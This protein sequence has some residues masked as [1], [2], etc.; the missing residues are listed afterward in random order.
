MGS[1]RL[2]L[3]N[4][5]I[6]ASLAS[7]AS[8]A[9]EKTERDSPLARASRLAASKNTRDRVQALRWL[10]ALAKP[11]KGPQGDEATYRYAELCLRFHREGERGAL[12][13]AKRAFTE[14][15]SKSR[16]RWGLLG[17][18]GTLRIMAAEGKRQE[19]LKQLDRFLSTQGKDDAFVDAAFYMGCLLAEDKDSLQSL[20]KARKAC[21]YALGLLKSR[22][23]YYAGL[24]T[25][26]RIRR[27][28]RQLKWD[29]DKLQLGRDFLMYRTAES[30]R[31][32]RRDLKKA[33]SLYL[34]VVKEHP[35][36][37][38]AE[39]SALYA[40]LC[41]VALNRPA[42]AHGELVAFYRA[43][44]RGLYRGEALLE[45]ARLEI[46]YYIR[47]DAARAY[48]GQLK[49][50]MRSAREDRTVSITGVKQAAKKLVAPP[51]TEK[52][53]D[54]WGNVRRQ[55][56][57]PGQLV[58]RLTCSWYLDEI[59]E[60][61]AAF[62]GF[63]FFAQGRRKEALECYR[64]LLRSDS[65]IRQMEEQGVWNNYSRLKWGAEHGYLFAMPQDLAQYRGRLRFAV[66]LGDFYYCTQK[67]DRAQAVFGR[68]LKGEF[69]KLSALQSDY[70]HYAVGSC[71]YRSL[72]KDRRRTAAFREWEKVIA[73]RE[74]TL[75]EDR[76]QLS[77]AQVGHLADDARVWK[78]SVKL[79][80]E[81][82][83]A[84]RDND[85][86]WRAR[87]LYAKML[88]H[89]DKPKEGFAL[90]DQVAAC[91]NKEF[92][93]LAVFWR[94]FYRKKLKSRKPEE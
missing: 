48:L 60:Q 81:L 88:V 4:W 80:A 45:L 3:L 63:L 19:A 79:A 26:E 58:N 32:G 21:N 14:L 86:V 33:R 54:F 28:L 64:E 29:M 72:G 94:D 6:L 59:Q 68:V 18:V 1:T 41:S 25:E 42:E 77:M 43:D 66:L 53:S 23:K 31:R 27:A 61:A 12:A 46:E 82:A 69:G 24:L 84:R 83:S 93:E 34:K 56:I 2:L 73:S 39:A 5:M 71:L 13:E 9:G 11:G 17:K 35:G 75:L 51:K 22:G 89:L 87:L 30:L 40:P 91:S 57:A 67:F 38:Y 92:R 37:V 44:K 76:T 65:Q 15:Q 90:Y 55:R 36:N 7:S 50:W 8:H 52:A 78:R 70:P 49:S 47:P 10:K 85:Y 74:G 20:G 62:R 16:T